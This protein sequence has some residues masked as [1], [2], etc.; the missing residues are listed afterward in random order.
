MNLSVGKRGPWRWALLALLVLALLAAL[1]A[2]LL[3]KVAADVQVAG[4]L[5]TQGFSVNVDGDTVH[6]GGAGTG[7]VLLALGGVLAALLVLLCAV[8]VI[9]VLAL[10]AAALAIGIAL[11]AVLAVAAIVLSPVWLTA[12]G[13]WWLLRPSRLRPV[14]TA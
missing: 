9:V 4:A 14:A 2:T 12:L 11:L 5:P 8:P 7:T 3:L 13:L 10:A 6:I 1:S